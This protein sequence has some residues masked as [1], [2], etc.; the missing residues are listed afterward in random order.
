MAHPEMYRHRRPTRCVD[1]LAALLVACAKPSVPVGVAPA[2][3]ASCLV[4]AD[5]TA[6]ALTDVRIVLP[7][8]I[9]LEAAPI[10]GSLGE[11]I[12]Q[13]QL[14]APLV[15]SDCNGQVVAGLAERWRSD[16]TGR[17]WTFDVRAGQ[18]FSGGAPID[19]MAVRDSW[20][21]AGASPRDGLSLLEP[22][23]TGPLTLETAVV[24]PL[25]AL[26]AAFADVALAVVGSG[27]RGAPSAESG[28]FRITR[29]ARA[30]GSYTSFDLA[31]VAEGLGPRLHVDV[32]PADADLRDVLDRQQVAIAR[33]GIVIARDP[34][35]LSY[36]R[37][38]PEFTVVPLP[39]DRTY[40]AIAS[41]ASGAA[42]PSPEVRSSLARDA[43]RGDAR[44]AEPPYWWENAPACA[45]SARAQPAR[46]TGDVAYLAGDPI[47]RELAE[48]IVALA[49]S[50]E[51]APW[52][53][54]MLAGHL[55]VRPLFRAVGFGKTALD[56]A[57]GSGRL[58]AAIVPYPRLNPV[59]CEGF[60][61]APPGSALVPLVDSRAHV[62]AL[63]G[64]PSFVIDADGAIRFLTAAAP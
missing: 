36:A 40:V 57:L 31:P 14:Y 27:G 44:A 7:G 1:L 20:P 18:R 52:V 49:G 50:S 56:S 22:I 39:W 21:R 43:V 9:R 48:R 64:V 10:F 19:A 28:A 30:G 37:G 34:T 26:P 29:S 24:E 58:A 12:V 62:I 5:S 60:V 59:V 61:K 13:K 55:A 46:A 38:H 47:A 35:A 45:R 17:R 16:P 41:A 51:R 54:A 32:V 8:P 33:A 63:R 15:R 11:L 2:A 23:V 6:P 42:H 3:G 53:S 25:E 4:R